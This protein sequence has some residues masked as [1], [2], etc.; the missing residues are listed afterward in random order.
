VLQQAASDPPAGTSERGNIVDVT[1]VVGELQAVQQLR[2]GGVTPVPVLVVLG[3][4][5]VVVAMPVV[6]TIQDAHVAVHIVQIL[7]RIETLQK[8]SLGLIKGLGS[9]AG[10]LRHAAEQSTVQFSSVQFSSVQF[11]Q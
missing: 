2:L 3:V 1:V 4:V 9:T 7:I 6:V 11:S 8:D 10:T 5:V